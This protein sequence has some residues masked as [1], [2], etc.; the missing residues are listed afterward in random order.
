MNSTQHKFNTTHNA[1]VCLKP[2]K[3]LTRDGILQVLKHCP[4][5]KTAIDEGART[6]CEDPVPTCDNV[7]GK[8]FSVV[9]RVSCSEVSVI[10]SL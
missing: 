9:L 2:S 7:C 6:S 8:E 5:G 1:S 4:C 10:W 3:K